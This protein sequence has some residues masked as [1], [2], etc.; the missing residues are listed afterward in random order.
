MQCWSEISQA[1]RGNAFGLQ[2]SCSRSDWHSKADRRSRGIRDSSICHYSRNSRMEACPAQR[3]RRTREMVGGISRPPAERFGRT[4]ER[5]QP[6]HCGSFGKFSCG[7]RGCLGGACT[8][9]PIG[10]R[11]SIDN[12][13]ATN[14]CKIRLHLK[15]RDDCLRGHH[16]LSV[17]L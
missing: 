3:Q 9:F 7:A 15:F 2:G 4:A 6:E 14:V 5:Q 11:E 13:R 1:S 16:T 10:E 12:G 17:A 8:T